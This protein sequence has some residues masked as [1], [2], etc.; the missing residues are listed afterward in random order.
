MARPE[1]LR[2]LVETNLR[3]LGRDHLDVVH[4]AAVDRFARAYGASPAQVRIGEP[5]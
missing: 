3:T 5:E 2:N 1:E 4:N